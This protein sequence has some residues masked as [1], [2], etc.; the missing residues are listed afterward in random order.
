MLEGVADIF[1]YVFPVSDEVSDSETGRCAYYD[2]NVFVAVAGCGFD[3]AG[4]I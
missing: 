3:R 4:G 1:G 2:K